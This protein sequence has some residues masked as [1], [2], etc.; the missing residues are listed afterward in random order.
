MLQIFSCCAPTVIYPLDDEPEED[1]K[2]SRDEIEESIEQEIQD[3]LNGKESDKSSDDE[4]E[5]LRLEALSKFI[6]F[7]PQSSFS[8]F[9]FYFQTRRNRKDRDL[10][11]V[12][13]T[14][15]KMTSWRPWGE[16]SWH[17]EPRKSQMIWGNIYFPSSKLILK[18]ILTV[19]LEHGLENETKCQRS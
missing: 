10:I 1:E 18:V 19:R 4:M 14:T 16:S 12:G 8:F 13:Q 2:E 15:Q 9:H 5:K 6:P 11:A 3:A 17:S 7:Q